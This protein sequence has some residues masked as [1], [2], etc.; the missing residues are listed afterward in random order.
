MEQRYIS[1]VSLTP[2][3]NVVVGQHHTPTALT[4]VKTRHPMYRKLGVP[5]AVLEGSGILSTNGIPNPDRATRSESLYLL[6]YSDRS[7]PCVQEIKQPKC[8]T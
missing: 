5:R 3:L 8:E 7:I 4:P 2:V 6:R 1:K